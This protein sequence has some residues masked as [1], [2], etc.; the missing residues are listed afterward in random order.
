MTDQRQVLSDKI[1]AHLPFARDKQYKVRDSDL[2]GFFVL[3]GTRRKS[4]MAQG[5]F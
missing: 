1:I 2:A 5:E 4:F 3:I